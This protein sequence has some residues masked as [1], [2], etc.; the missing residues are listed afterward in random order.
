VTYLLPFSQVVLALVLPVVEL[1][2]NI[3]LHFDHPSTLCYPCALTLFVG[4]VQERSEQVDCSGSH[5]D[6]DVL[7][8]YLD[9]RGY[10]NHGFEVET[11]VV[12]HLS[13]LQYLIMLL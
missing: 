5:V 4:W 1:L 10:W 3:G 6:G 7:Y 13:M 8:S 12:C 2:E 9:H 11:V